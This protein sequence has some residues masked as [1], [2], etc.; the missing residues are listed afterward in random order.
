MSKDESKADPSDICEA[1]TSHFPT[2]W[3]PLTARGVAAFSRAT[4][5]RLLFIQLIV[6]LLVAASILWFLATNWFPTVREAIRQLPETGQI[7]NQE[8]VSPRT[9]TAPL[10]ETRFLT[11]VM[12][13]EGAGIPSLKADLRVE[14]HRRNFA[15]CS[16]LGCLRIDYPKGQTVLFSRLELES[17]WAAWEPVIYSVIGLSVVAW[18]FL[19]WVVLATL[20]CPLARIYAFFK[21][22]Q[23]T[24]PGGWKLSAAA[25]LPAA[26]M[27]GA[28][29]VL[30]GLGLTDLIGFLVLFALHLAVG[31]AYLFASPLRLPRASD[32]IPA[33][34][35]NPFTP[36]GPAPSNPFVDPSASTPQDTAP[37]PDS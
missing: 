16:A 2:A 35:Q 6:A 32:A 1:K 5:G 19:T 10:A 17:W 34:R 12:D 13:V 27:T 33:V 15:L 7:R 21:D 36:P 8:L 37:N 29:I 25:L 18:L 31:W 28:G 4:L 20:Y 14:F 23:L 24:L 3:Q 11:L 30:Y 22:R 9:S 26:L